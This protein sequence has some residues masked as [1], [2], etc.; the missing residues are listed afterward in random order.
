M[1]TTA[2]PARRIPPLGGFNL[3]FLRLE[4][5]RLLRNRRTVI[6]TLVPPVVFFLIF[7]ANQSYSNEPAGSGNVEAFVMISMAV[8]GAMLGTTATGAMV[9]VERAQ[10]WSR[11]LRLT[12]LKPVAY[13]VVKVLTATLVGLASIAAVYLA[14]GITGAHM[15]VSVWVETVLIAWVGSLVFAAFGLFMGYLLPTEN[16]MQI[17]GPVLAAL[18]FL[19]GLFIPLD[20]LGEPFRTLAQFSPMYGLNQLVHA[21]LMHDALTWGAIVNLLFWAAAFVA[22]AAWRFRRDTARV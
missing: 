15:P 7:G 17:L 22:G 20:Q 14:G 12:P 1:T 13:I 3:T 19:G 16:I 18:A 21:P 10:G 4:I 11:Q 9:S 2:V 6:F 5:R 8:Y